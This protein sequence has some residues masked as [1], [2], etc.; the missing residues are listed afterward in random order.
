MDKVKKI[1]LVFIIAI[2]CIFFVFITKDKVNDAS[3]FLTM[4]TLGMTGLIKF[5]ASFRKNKNKE[6]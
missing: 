2:I 3:V 1:F 4:F 5:I 6:E